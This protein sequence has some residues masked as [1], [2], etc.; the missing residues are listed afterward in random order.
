M[1]KKKNDHHKFDDLIEDHNLYKRF[2]D[3]FNKD[4]EDMF[5]ALKIKKRDE[6]DEEAY[7]RLL[8][9]HLLI[10]SSNF[11]SDITDH[12]Y[13]L[14]E[15]LEGIKSEKNFTLVMHLL[16]EL[17]IILSRIDQFTNES[18]PYDHYKDV[19]DFANEMEGL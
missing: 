17:K 8:I 2:V 14:I 7:Q 16:N 3:K 19:E 15:H 10:S 18:F 13:F 1:S 6:I 12:I 5:Y 11:S 4:S 9:H